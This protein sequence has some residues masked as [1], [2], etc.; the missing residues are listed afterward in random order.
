MIDFR[1]PDEQP[2]P[3]GARTE[4]AG[5]ARAALQPTR[6]SRML[7][8]RSAAGLHRTEGRLQEHPRRLRRQPHRLPDEHSI[9]HAFHH[10]A[11]LV[12]SNGDPA[13]YGSITSKWEHFAEWKRNGERR[14]AGLDAET[15]LDGMLATIACSTS[16]R[17]SSCSTIAARGDTQNRGRNHQVLGVNNRG[18]VGA[19]SGSVEKTVST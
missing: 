19:P 13:R 4:D 16:S 8:E 5:R 15:L 3:G 1:N 17:T 10:N 12:V 9:A 18:R 6:R 14:T 11:F 7:R 2:L